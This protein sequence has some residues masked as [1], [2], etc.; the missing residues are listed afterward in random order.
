MKFKKNIAFCCCGLKSLIMSVTG[1]AMGY[2]RMIRSGGLHFVSNSIRFV[3]DLDDLQN[4]EKLSFDEGL[5][6][7][8]TAEAAKTLDQIVQNL[9]KSFTEGSEYFQVRSTLLFYPR[10]NPI[11]EILPLK[12]KNYS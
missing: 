10:G 11:K 1:N 2:V 3:P 9:S 7:P 6:D 5:T 8:E 12:R 4:F